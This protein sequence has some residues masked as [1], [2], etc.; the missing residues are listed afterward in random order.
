[1]GWRII[2]NLHSSYPVIR[3]NG[4]IRLGRGPQLFKPQEWLEARCY[5]RTMS[6]SPTVLPD[7]T[8]YS[9]WQ[10]EKGCEPPIRSCS[11][12]IYG[13]WRS[14]GNPASRGAT[15]PL[16]SLL[17][18]SVILALG[19]GKVIWGERHQWRA[20]YVRPAAIA[21]HDNVFDVYMRDALDGDNSPPGMRCAISHKG[22]HVIAGGQWLE[23]HKAA[24]RYYDIPVVSYSSYKE[25][26][27]IYKAD[28]EPPKREKGG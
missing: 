14:I 5:P 11:C 25:L 28:T 24:A 12:G 18:P 13:Y 26:A 6:D 4:S 17:L 16:E 22:Q 19:K 21:L 10:H 20:Q 1:M 15:Q 27:Q 8:A 2:Y 23:R 7:F 3:D 9:E